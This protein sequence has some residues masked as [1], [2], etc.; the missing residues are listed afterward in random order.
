MSKRTLSLLTI[1]ATGLAL[2]ACAKGSRLDELGGVYTERSLCPQ[3]G[4]PAA[5]GDITLFH[6]GGTAADFYGIG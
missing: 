6:P 5:T 4:I 2:S 1:L 3:L